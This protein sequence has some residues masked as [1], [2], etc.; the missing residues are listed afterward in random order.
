MSQMYSF[1]RDKHLT[2]GPAFLFM[3]AW[4]YL[5]NTH[6]VDGYNVE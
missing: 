5:N 6:M 3:E 2:P 1:L 4:K